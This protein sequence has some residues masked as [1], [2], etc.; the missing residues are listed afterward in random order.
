MAPKRTS[1]NGALV[2]K[3]GGNPSP[4]F[5]I[6]SIG[7]MTKD[8]SKKLCILPIDTKFGSRRPFAIRATF[9]YN[10]KTPF[11]QGGFG[12]FLFFAIRQTRLCQC[13][14]DFLSLFVW[15]GGKRCAL[16]CIFEMNMNPTIFSG[17]FEHFNIAD[18]LDVDNLI[19]NSNKH[20]FV[21]LFHFCDYIISY[22]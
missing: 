19:F 21:P 8:F 4:F 11:C 15:A 17:I 22:F 18:F 20:C 7:K 3:R 13:V 6:L 12:I 14:Y 9:H 10:T 16:I 2:C 1:V 5:G